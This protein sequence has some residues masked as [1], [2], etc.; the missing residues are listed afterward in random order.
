MHR[1]PVSG[2]DLLRRRRGPPPRRVPW[3]APPLGLGLRVR[4]GG[5]AHGRASG[6]PASAPARST[7][8]RAGSPCVPPPDRRQMRGQAVFGEEHRPRTPRPGGR[9]ALD[10]HVRHLPTYSEDVVTIVHHA[11]HDEVV[12]G[13]DRRRRGAG[14]RSVEAVHAPKDRRPPMTIPH[15]K[16][17]CHSMGQPSFLATVAGAFAPGWRSGWGEATGFTPPTA[18]RP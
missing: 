8:N 6:R 4:R 13:R 2:V 11:G 7:R 1:N 15:R 17:V 18:A 5:A 9:D 12:H 16:N 3:P 14:A 10:C